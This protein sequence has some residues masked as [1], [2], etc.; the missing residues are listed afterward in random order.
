MKSLLFVL[1]SILAGCASAA[2]NAVQVNSTNAVLTSP[3]GFFESNNVARL[4]AVNASNAVQD[5]TIGTKASTNTTDALAATNAAQDEAISSKV[6]T[7]EMGDG[8]TY[9]NGQ[10][11]VTS[12]GTVTNID[13]NRKQAVVSNGVAAILINADDIGAWSTNTPVELWT[14]LIGISTVSNATLNNVGGLSLTILTD[15]N[16]AA[17]PASNNVW[18]IYAVSVA[19]TNYLMGVDYLTNRT[20]IGSA[21]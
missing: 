6:S 20:W 4:S 21:P 2:N 3:T 11:I 16:A 19:G 5:A 13:V 7:S 17:A 12:Q 1:V 18:T 14:N 10:W 8:L 15:T 9:S